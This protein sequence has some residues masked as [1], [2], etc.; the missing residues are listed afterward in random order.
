MLGTLTNFS[1]PDQED[2]HGEV[3]LCVDAPAHRRDDLHP[4]APVAR[5]D[6]TH[7]RLARRAAGVRLRARLR[8]LPARP[9]HRPRLAPPKRSG[10]TGGTSA[11][12]LWANAARPPKESRVVRVSGQA[13]AATSSISP[14]RTAVMRSLR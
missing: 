7:D 8:A 1:T 14:T 12:R 4:L 9:G 10:S 3:L 5:A 6:R 13:S 11:A 2:N